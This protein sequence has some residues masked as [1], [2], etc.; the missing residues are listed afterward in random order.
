M[1]LQ[2]PSRGGIWNCALALGNSCNARAERS[3]RAQGI[4]SDEDMY[5]GLKGHMQADNETP[6]T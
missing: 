6:L 2:Q 3:L 1:K 5:P 4:T